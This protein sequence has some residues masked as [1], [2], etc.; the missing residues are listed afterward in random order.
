V[1][2]LIR[3]VPTVLVGFFVAL[4][5]IAGGGKKAVAWSTADMKWVENPMN[6]AISTA[7]LWGDP[8]RGAYGVIRKAAAG[9]DLGWHTHSADEKVIVISGSFD[10]QLEGEEPMTLSPGSYAFI[11]A[12]VNH[13]A[14]CHEGADCMFFEEGPAKSDFKPGKAPAM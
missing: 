7:T 2:A 13:M 6:K 12:N 9:T 4:I 10:F 14:K 1:K 3:I 5:L 8:A 11:P